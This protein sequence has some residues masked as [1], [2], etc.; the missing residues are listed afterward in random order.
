MAPPTVLVIVVGLCASVAGAVNYYIDCSA[1]GAGSGTIQS[2]WNSINQVN[3]PIFQAGD[4]IAFKAGTQC[5]GT[6]SPKGVGTAGAVIQITKYTQGASTDTNPIINGAGAP[7]AITLTN[8]DYWRISNL[9]VTNPATQLAAR[10]GI[11]V[12]AT[13]GKTHTDITIDS[14]T[15]HHVAGQTNKASQATDFSLSCGILVNRQ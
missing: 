2:P 3:V 7:A 15:V 4:V 14:N 1:S 8:Q 6:L 11:H 12:T 5:T 13:D 9:T 10:Q